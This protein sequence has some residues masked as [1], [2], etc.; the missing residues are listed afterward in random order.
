MVKAA[1]TKL[2]SWVDYS[3]FHSS[4]LNWVKGS[5]A[6]F[7]TLHGFA[8][9]GVLTFAPPSGILYVLIHCGLAVGGFL[10]IV[11]VG[12][13]ILRETIQAWHKRQLNVEFGF[14]IGILLLYFI[15]LMASVQRQ[16]WVFYEVIPLALTLFAI[17]RYWVSRKI[18]K[19]SN[20]LPIIFDRVERCNRVEPT[21][22]VTRIPLSDL[23]FGDEIKISTSQVVPVDGVISKGEGYVS[24]S[25]LNGST[26]PL[27]KQPGDPILAGSVSLDGVFTLKTL[28]PYVSRKMQGSPHTLFS[29]KPARKLSLLGRVG[30][31]LLLTCLAIISFV[32]GLYSFGIYP[33]LIIT[34]SVLILGAS[35]SWIQGIPVQYWTGLVHLSD[36]GL[37]GKQP[38]LIEQLANVNRVYLGKTGVLTEEELVLK[39][40]FV[41]P[42]YQDREDWIKSLVFQ[43]S[44]MIHHPVIN[45]LAA[46]GA[47][48]QDDPVREDLKYKILPGKGV[49][50]TLTD[51]LGNQLT[52]RIGEQDYILGN[53]GLAAFNPIIEEHDLLTGQR[54]WISLDNRVCAIAQLKESWRVAPQQFFLQLGQLGIRSGILT[55]DKNFDDFR[56][57]GLKCEQGLSAADKQKSVQR[58]VTNGSRVLA[59]GD[60]LNDYRAMT[61]ARISVAMKHA[62]E[63][64][65]SSSSAIL[66]SDQL[67]TIPFS[68]PYCRK[69][70]DLSRIN[71]WV[72]SSAVISATVAAAFGWLNPLGAIGFFLAG[73]AVIWLQS[74]LIGSA[75][76]SREISSLDSMAKTRRSVELFARNR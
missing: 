50:F 57:E 24:E 56:L 11:L 32:F 54:I 75:T 42:A 73:F 60:G 72:F 6:I 9:R 63:A 58:A 36:R 27:V 53:R 23:K 71:S 22:A 64:L 28:A 35:L 68:I 7:L 16:P 46:V 55:S 74:F 41:M 25:S 3:L 4:D 52:L 14:L 51:G 67:Q 31:S 33:A 30:C 70:V 10:A 40:F 76:L 2:I 34:S 45:P 69:I 13:Q 43:T 38:Q 66:N 61:A 26:F 12:P 1:S 39:Q 47:L 44:K 8:L 21:G 49:E 29:P 20:S 59:I 62:P 18:R 15:S 17:S 5:I 37:F 19:V 65:L 48:I